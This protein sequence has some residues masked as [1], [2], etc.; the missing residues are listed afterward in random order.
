MNLK[1]MPETLE[2]AQPDIDTSSSLLFATGLVKSISEDKAWVVTRRSNG[3]HS[4][5]SQKSCGTS[6]LSQ[7]FSP[8]NTTAVAVENT[9]G[10]K[11]GDEVMLSMDESRLI[12]HSIMAYGLPLLGLFVGALTFQ[13]LG[14]SSTDFYALVGALFG[15]AS[16]WWFTRRFY[17]PQLPQLHKVIQRSNRQKEQE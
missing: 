12:H 8:V 15:L 4:C 6:V 2:R 17:R 3:C 13:W 7:L 5:D 1:D 14:G 10:V 16:G 9:L 11:A